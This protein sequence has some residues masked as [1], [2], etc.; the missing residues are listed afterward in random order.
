MAFAERAQSLGFDDVWVNDH[1][2][3][4]PELAGQPP[5]GSFEAAQAAPLTFFES[6]TTAGL[7]MGRLSHIGVAIGGLA[8]PLRE[9]RML[10]KQIGS[11]HELGGRR[12]TIAPAIGSGRDEFELLQ[13]PFERRGRLTDEYLAV[14]LGLLRSAEPMSFSGSTVSFEAA[15]L[16]PR[17]VGLRV[18]IAGESDAA[19]RRAVRWADG[20]LTSY[21]SAAEYGPHLARLRAFASA[22]Q[23]DPESLEPAAIVPL[24]LADS[25]GD[26]VTIAGATL[27]ARFG[28]LERGMVCCAVGG[29]GDVQAH[30]RRLHDA[31][32]RYAQLR[33]IGHDLP[34]L[35]AMLNRLGTEVLPALRS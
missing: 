6:L 28:S 16:A 3:I 14:L 27:V 23:R 15:A 8:L 26:A 21:P 34:S 5:L 30:L 13:V 2:R 7:L 17:P 32:L 9:P 1:I 10:A 19:L 25:R 12:L 11:L 29:P 22:A 18:W 33:L 4:G 20:W 35:Q 31:G 24:C